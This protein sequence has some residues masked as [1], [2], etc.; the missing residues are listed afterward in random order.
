[1]A[2]YTEKE[3]RNK[4]IEYTVYNGKNENGSK[5]KIG[6]ITFNT[7]NGKTT[8]EYEKGITEDEKMCV[9]IFSNI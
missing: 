8:I 6:T 9:D 2:M 4:F 1:M 3:E 5:R 7:I